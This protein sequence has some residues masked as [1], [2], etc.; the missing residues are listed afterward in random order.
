[1]DKIRVIKSQTNYDDDTAKKKLEQWNGDYMKVIREYLNPK[2]DEPK[3]K[4]ELPVNQKI[5]TEIR[6]FMDDINREAFK[7]NN[8]K[9]DEEYLKD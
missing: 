6:N 4:K 5:M 9:F 2:F 8:A 7:K 3:K 1:M